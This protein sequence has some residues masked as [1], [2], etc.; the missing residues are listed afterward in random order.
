MFNYKALTRNLEVICY[1][2]VDL[3]SCSCPAKYRI[4][5]GRLLERMISVVLSYVTEK[6]MDIIM[7]RV[8]TVR[9]SLLKGLYSEK[10]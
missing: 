10:I 8:N 5:T 2:F 7:F 3:M 6:A 4:K 1:Y 9:D